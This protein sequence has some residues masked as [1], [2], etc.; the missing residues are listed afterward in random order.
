MN[1]AILMGYKMTVVYWFI[2]LYSLFYFQTTFIFI[3]IL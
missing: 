3:V 2:Q 1:T